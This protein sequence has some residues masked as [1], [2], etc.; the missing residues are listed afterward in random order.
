MAKK[1]DTVDQTVNEF[2]DLAPNTIWYPTGLTLL[3]EVVGGGLGMGYPGGKF[4]NIA[5]SFGSSKTYVAWHAIAANYYYWKARGVDFYWQFDDAEFGSTLDI[6]SIYGVPVRPE[7]I[8]NSSSVEMFH[9]NFVNF[10]NSIP[11]G[12]RGIYVLDS[13]DPLK[14]EAELAAVGKDVA[15]MLDGKMDARGSYDMAKQKYLSSRFFPYVVKP[16]EEKQIVCLIISQ[17]R[18]NVQTFGFGPKFNIS[19]GRAA[20][21]YYNARLMLT[22]QRTHS[23]TREG[24]AIEIGMGVLAK[25]QK[26]K[27][28]RPNRECQFDLYYT[29]GIDD[30]GACVDYLFDL[31]SD[32][33]LQK[34]TASI[35]WDGQSFKTRDAL[36]TYVRENKQIRAIQQATIDRWE[37]IEAAASAVASRALPGNDWEEMYTALAEDTSPTETTKEAVDDNR[38]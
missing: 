16:M 8:V 27:C 29:Q 26:N 17:I 20:E 37:R 9:A 14:T 25:L 33:G 21:H 23:V 7:N 13:L 28:P 31:K 22:R 38:D 3:D 15:K 5:G 12:A 30:L 6:E 18:D 34:K 4:T 11:D 10:M 1:K 19:G 24:R 32:T 36:I 35:Q 2:F